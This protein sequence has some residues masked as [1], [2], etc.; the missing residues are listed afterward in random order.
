MLTLVEAVLADSAQ[1]TA[2]LRVN[3]GTENCA[4]LLHKVWH[5]LYSVGRPSGL[6]LLD[7]LTFQKVFNVVPRMVG[8]GGEGQLFPKEST[9]RDTRSLLGMVGKIRTNFSYAELSVRS[10]SSHQ[11]IYCLV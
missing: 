4:H 5:L 11:R 9:P 2:P 3:T 7:T 6:R 8:W 1:R 10:I